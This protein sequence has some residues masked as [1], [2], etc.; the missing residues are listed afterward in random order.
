MLREWPR[1]LKIHNKAKEVREIYLT[2]AKSC[3]AYL[4]TRVKQSCVWRLI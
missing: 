4:E 1:V 3:N 2:T